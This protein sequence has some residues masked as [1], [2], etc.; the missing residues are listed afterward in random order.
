M[1][2]KNTSVALILT[3][4]LIIGLG[5]YSAYKFFK[6][7]INLGMDLRGGLHVVLQAQETAGKPVTTDTIQK[8]VSIM[9]DRVDS[10]GVKETNVYTQGKDR[11]V[12]DIAGETDPEQ[13]INI[14]GK[15]AQ[16][17]FKDEAGTLLLTGD[18]LVEAKAGPNPKNDG[19]FVVNLEF[20]KAGADLFSKATSANLGKPL[21]IFL[22]NEMVSAPRVNTA[23]TDGKCY[24]ESFD[25][26]TANQ[27]AVQLRSGALPVSLKMLEKRTV[28]PTL[29]AD[30]LDKSVKAGIIGIIAILVFM[31]GYYRLPGLVADI[32]LVVY[33][34]LV[35]GTMYFLGAVLTVPGIAGF[36]LSIGMAVDANVIIYERIKEEL[37]AGKTI[38]AGI[39]AG[40]KR[41][42]WTIFDANLTTLITALI[43]MYFGTGAVKGFAVTLSIGLVAT[44]L[45]ALTVTRYLLV[46][47]ANLT[48]NHKLYGV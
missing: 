3:L 46:L 34:I 41:A 33:S 9:K 37:R 4:M 25:A 38:H 18:H 44:V 27:L 14:L 40:F 31:L 48:G 39:D 10:L 30:S 16:L 15:T 6:G 12:V 2:H 13:A 23:I 1:V 19:S 28:G 29:G 43:L 5:G 7:R 11:V 8:A 35:L 21:V 17:E 45:V 22:D 20:D 47:F 24:I 32:S 36:I 26:T 42:F